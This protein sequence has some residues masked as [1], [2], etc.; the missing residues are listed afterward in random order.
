M[1]KKAV[2]WLYRELPD[3]IQKGIVTPEIAEQLKKHYGPAETTTGT[4]TFLMIFGVIGVVLVGLGII[5][6]LAHN[7]AALTK[8]TRLFIS[9]GLLIVAQIASGV[10]LAR[11][12]DSQVWLESTA[13][14]QF[15]MVGASI[16]LVGQTYHLADDTD[17]FIRTWMLLALPLIYLMNS[18]FVAVLYVV[19][20]TFWASSSANSPENQLV[21]LFLILV[22][23]YYWH[24][25][26]KDRYSNTTFIA[27][28][29]LN[30]CLYIS[31]AAAFSRTIDQLGPLLYSALFTINYLGGVFW[32][33]DDKL[34]WQMPFK[35][36][37]LAGNTV[38]IF[39]L[40]FNDI[41]R[42]LEL[43]TQAIS[44]T[45]G[46]L[47]LLSLI[48]VIAGNML[49]IRKTGWTNIQYSLAPLIIG[50]AY[51]LKLYNESGVIA[52]ILLNCFLL[53]I[54][55]STFVTGVRKHKLGLVNIGM[56]LLAALIIARF[57]DMNFSFVIR[58]LVFVLLGAAFLG[59]NLLMVRRKSGGPA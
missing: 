42:H 34:R 35:I 26:R 1:N 36:I 51:I 29:I 39:M 8:L 3:L 47:V 4:R 58:G 2:D 52:T 28:W 19:G 59:T 37:G 41:W 50:S 56:A 53:V 45:E 22:A 13:T 38:L 48:L 9:V 40:T 16:A 14:L 12:R 31:F 54:S 17:T 18:R 6:I 15:L 5:L 10:T 49:Y 11:K 43:G 25:I 20:V 33:N 21:W 23:P 32:F 46:V 27:C 7:W 30:I 44:V 24:L 57:L 55:I